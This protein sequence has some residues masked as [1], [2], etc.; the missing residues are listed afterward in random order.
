MYTTGRWKLGLLL[1]I[2]T[3][4][5]WGVLPIALKALLDRID[6]YTLTWYRFLAAGAL[7]GGFLIHRR[8]LPSLRA[9][10]GRRWGLFSVA[11]VGLTGN[12]LLYLFG[13]RYVTPATS[14]MVIQ[15]APVFLLLGGLVFFRESFRPTQW[16]GLLVLVAG[17]AFFFNN[18]LDELMN[19]GGRY[20]AGVTITVVAALVWAA[21]A[22]AQKQLLR[23]FDSAQIL[24]LIYAAAVVFI[25]PTVE[26][27]QIRG[28]SRL[29]WGLLIFCC[30]NTVIAYGAFAEALVHWEASRVSSVLAITPLITL[31]SIGLCARWFPGLVEP[32]RINTLSVV[33]ACMVV[34]GSAAAALGRKRRNG[35][36]PAPLK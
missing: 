3:A 25:L 33:G 7:L 32:E 18:R 2:L 13:L 5:M 10:G 24:L 28:L 22:L 34:A 1:A 20:H 35:A 21:Y 8:R 27:G 26:V 17:L 36:I 15:L 19:A 4:V 31:L 30:V 16:F 6:P 12:Y 29:E 23:S 14:Q 11:V 9:L